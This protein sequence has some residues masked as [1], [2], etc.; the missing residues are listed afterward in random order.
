VRERR[1]AVKAIVGAIGLAG[2]TSTVNAQTSPEVR[3]RMACSFPK[4]LD[5]AFGAALTISTT[6]SELTSGKFVIS[7]HG[8]GEIA[9][10]LGVLDA[11]QQR[12]VECGHSGGAIR[13]HSKEWLHRGKNCAHFHAM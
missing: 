2:A 11:V 10:A 6:V 13:P 9:P 12:T 7:V 4:V 1:T 3:W 5:T 8:P